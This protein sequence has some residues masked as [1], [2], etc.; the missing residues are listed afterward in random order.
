[1]ITRAQ[2]RYLRTGPQKTRLVVDQI[3][4]R[5]VNDALSLL[6]HHKR[7]VARD[8]EK[9][10]RSAVANATVKVATPPPSVVTSPVV[11][12]TSMAGAP[13]QQTGVMVVIV[14]LQPPAMLP[15]SV[16]KSSITKSDHVPLGSSPSS[17]LNALP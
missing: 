15:S 13:V 9:L 12:L 1:M 4:N 8:L 5:G 14:R 16:K 2:L 11:G 6:Q 10:L 17:S 3:R 7:A